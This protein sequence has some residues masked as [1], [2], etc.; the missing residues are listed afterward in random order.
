MSDAPITLEEALDHEG[1]V[2]TET[3]ATGFTIT[4]DNGQIIIPGMTLSG[5]AWRRSLP[6]DPGDDLWLTTIPVFDPAYRP[7]IL[8]HILDRYR[9]RRL[10]Y[11][12]P[13]EWRLAFRRWCN[14]HIPYYNR[15]YQSTA[16]VLPLDTMDI[17]DTGGETEGIS[18]TGSQT[19]HT[20]DMGSDFP[21]SAIS[22]SAEYASTATDRRTA[23]NTADDSNRD[24]TDQHHKTGR[25]QSVMQLVREQRDLIINV[26]EMVLTA[27]DELFLSVFDG[28]ITAHVSHPDYRPY[29][30][31]WRP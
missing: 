16:I 13:G 24:K 18:A 28:G 9:S 30:I 11:G 7:I 22:G 21:Q 25:D 12:T 10:A 1:Y 14:L 19:D 2:I 4:L 23:T 20:L 6:P 31:G 29:G 15:Y 5:L 17:T 27:M 8:S 26:D 3:A